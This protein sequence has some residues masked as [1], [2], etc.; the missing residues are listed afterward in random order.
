MNDTT[1]TQTGQP[2]AAPEVPPLVRPRD[3]RVIAGV[4]AG[5]AARLG[6]GTGW[7]RAGFVI[8][9][10]FGGIGLLFY[11][12]GWL[13]IPEEGEEESIAA[14][15]VS[16]L[17]GSSRWIGVALIVVGVLLVLGWTDAIRGEF[18]WAGALILAGV[19]LYRGEIPVL[20]RQT[21]PPASPP[22]PPPAP[23]APPVL[24]DDRVAAGVALGVETSDDTE[25]DIVLPAEA[26]VPP[27]PPVSPRPK[28]P[29][30]MLGRIT[31]AS[32]LIVLGAFAL[33]DNAGVIEP[34][35]RHYVGAA[36]GVVGLGLMAGAFFGRARG[37]IALGVL[38]LPVL[39]VASVVRVPF[40]GETG[41]RTFR[42]QTVTEVQDV[43]RLGAGEMSIDL[44]SI[45]FESGIVDLEATVGAGHLV[46]IVPA[47][48]GVEVD[49]RVGFGE[50][51][52]FGLVRSG[53]GREI[54]IEAPEGAEF[55]IAINVEVGFGQLQVIRSLR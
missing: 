28:S 22:P 17:E 19:L 54:N 3:D 43:Y 9:C 15:K 34:A 4:A 50:V 37:L 49:S 35:A 40:S 6:I 51:E 36:V 48:A 55:V 18:V 20:R 47:G 27:P 7:V 21:S 10:F 41:E 32:L 53:I 24:P 31:L 25:P 30:S 52:V 13:M 39:F 46:V 42:P 44:R 8:A 23:P 12:V 16:D 26:S 2:E 1:T 29:R 14:T 5:L 38:L 45:G 11:A 33:F